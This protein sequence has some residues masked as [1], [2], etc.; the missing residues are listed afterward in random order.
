MFDKQIDGPFLELVQVAFSRNRPLK[1][2]ADYR[3][4]VRF[5][6]VVWHLESPAGLVFPQ[7]GGKHSLTRC[8][9]VRAPYLAPWPILQISST[10][11][12]F[13]LARI[14]RLVQ[15]FSRVSCPCAQRLQSL[16]CATSAN[17]HHN[18]V[19][20]STLRNKGARGKCRL[21]SI[22]LTLHTTSPQNIGV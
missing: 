22:D 3:G 12:S 9:Q 13:L 20:P 7:I 14:T 10:N 8:H 21:Q 18:R 11:D 5:S 1:R 6:E 4:V 17:T 2:A 16:E 19:L 15:P